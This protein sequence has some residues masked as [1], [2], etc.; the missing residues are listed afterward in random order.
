MKTHT[1]LIRYDSLTTLEHPLF[2]FAFVFHSLLRPFL[3]SLSIR[4]TSVMAQTPCSKLRRNSMTAGNVL[5]IE[6]LS[7]PYSKLRQ[8]S[9]KAGI[10]LTTEVLLPPCSKLRRDSMTAGNVLTKDLVDVLEDIKELQQTKKL[11]PIVA[12]V[13]EERTCFQ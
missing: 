2:S 7:L 8:D 9:M 4:A 1:F 11:G 13:K 6:L 10:L 5:T 3:I 12:F